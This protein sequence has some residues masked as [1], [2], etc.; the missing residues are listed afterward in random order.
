MRFKYL[1]NKFMKSKNIWLLT[2]ERPKRSVLAIILHKFCKDNNI[3][4]FIDT[5]RIIPV[6]DKN[7]NFTFTYEII[8]FKSNKID[9]VFL[10]T[11]SGNGS[12]VDFMLFFQNDEPGKNDKPEYVIEETKTDDAESR[13][14]GV[15]QRA[16]K[17]V[18]AEFYYPDAKKIMMY[19]LQVK[20]K[21]EA[22][23]TNIFGTR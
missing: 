12:F 13:N 10:K 7:K 11:V 23:M 15:F 5:I 19:N 14:T 1:K 6:L 9:R 22:T 21:E 2:E 18:Y 20:Q 16:S 8:G 17:F 3:A 4:C